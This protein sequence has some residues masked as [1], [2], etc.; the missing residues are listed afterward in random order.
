GHE[1]GGPV[2][3]VSSSAHRLVMARATA[4]GRFVVECERLASRAR[5]TLLMDTTLGVIY[6]RYVRSPGREGAADAESARDRVRSSCA[7]D[8]VREPADGGRARRPEH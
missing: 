8:D 7:G 1:P 3:G 4:G 2:Q 6:A 5:E